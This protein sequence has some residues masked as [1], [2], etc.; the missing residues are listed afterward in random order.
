M[1]AMRPRP[2]AVLLLVLALLA[3]GGASEPAP[4]PGEPG[5]QERAVLALT[6]AVRIA[7]ADW[8]RNWSGGLG[9]GVLDTYP[10]VAPMR[11]NAALGASA[12][13]HSID[14]ATTSVTTTTPCF[15]HD[16]CDGTPWTQRIASHY[17]LS[18]TIGENIA[19]GYPDPEAVVQGWICDPAP[20]QS[21]CSQD[22]TSF[23]GHR[24][25]IMD[26]TWEAMGAGWVAITVGPFPQYWTQ[27]FGG[28]A[29]ASATASPLVDG[30]HLLRTGNTIRFFANYHAGG[31]PTSVALV[32]DG[33][34]HPLTPALGSA[35]RGT[36][37]LDL[38]RS[39]GCRSYRFEAVD[40]A[41][42]AWRYPA[43]GQLR[44]S[45]EGTCTSSFEP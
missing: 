39:A 5:W 17:R 10:P 6:N 12:R 27:D 30:S 34:S 32:L 8:K 41:G 37:A 43:A 3:C 23:A 1:P 42:A 4:A 16:S 13:A 11:W 29:E 2:P 28:K 19:A 36:Y 18:S 31:A 24:Q 33:A 20:N 38:P 14:M 22:G 40:A 35:A 15:Q 21:A 44:T 45:G 7:P 25:N 9:A 26:G